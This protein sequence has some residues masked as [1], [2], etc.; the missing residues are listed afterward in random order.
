LSPADGP[1]GTNRANYSYLTAPG[2]T[3]N[4]A[5]VI[6]SRATET[7]VLDVYAADGFTTPDGLLDLGVA[8]VQPEDAGAW[9]SF[10]D[11]I[12]GST[13]VP[14]AAYPAP[15]PGTG[16]ASAASPTFK[17]RIQV[18]LPAGGAVTVPFQWTV[19]AD[20]A[21]GDHAAGI[22]TSQTEALPGE[23]VAVDRRLALRAYFT[24]AGDLKPG[25][26]ISDLRVKADGGGSPFASGSLDV[27]YSLVN[28]GNARVV[29][30]E[31]IA[32][33]GPF[34]LGRHSAGDPQVLPEV[35]PGSYLARQAT[36]KGVFPLFRTTVEVTVDGVA[37]A[38]G[39]EGAVASAAGSKAVW[40]VPWV[41]LG[42]I[43]VVLVAA[44]GWPLWRARH[45]VQVADAADGSTG[46]QDQ[47]VSV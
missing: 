29:P 23:T 18:T 34:G 5:I 21:P 39:A 17:Q 32:T 20:A 22:V 47:A 31:R 4:D 25:L 37:I 15:A 8:A 16:G 27:R 26:T 1:L 2:N 30:T 7:L 40:T 45:R 14:D 41:W 6:S 24:V 36:V 11:P 44:V 43:I 35:L 3:I 38:V 28:T 46:G 9:A 12:D 10:G 13:P 33:H 19:P 42:I